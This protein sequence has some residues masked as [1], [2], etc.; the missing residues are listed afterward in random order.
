MTLKTNKKMC[1]RLVATL[2]SLAIVAMALSPLELAQ[3]QSNVNLNTHQLLVVGPDS[4]QST[5][6]KFVDFKNSQ[7]VSAHYVSTESINKTLSNGDFVL[8]LHNY[9]SQEI[10][11]SGLEYVILVGTYDQVPTKY[12]YSPSSD[13]DIADFNYKPTDWYYAV[14]NWND[15]QVGLFGGNIPQIAVGRLPV[16]DAQEL[17]QTISK[18]IFVEENLGKGSFVSLQDPNLGADSGLNVPCS[19]VPFNTN[20]TSTRLAQVLSENVSYAAT[21]THGTPDALWTQTGADK[22]APLFSSK[23]VASLKSTFGIM[24]VVA[25]FTGA[26]DLGEE[27]LARALITSPTGPALVIASSRT[28]S[29]NNYIPSAFWDKFFET[30][31]VGDSFVFSIQSY[32]SNPA[33]FSADLKAFQKYNFYLDKVIYGDVSWTINN[34]KVEVP[35]NLSVSTQPEVVLQKALETSSQNEDGTKLSGLWLTLPFGAV[36]FSSIL[37]GALWHVRRKNSEVQMGVLEKV[38]IVSSENVAECVQVE[39]LV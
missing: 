1:T 7:G 29:L 34:H 14:P 30:G 10:I 37:A 5:V 15:S 28:E 20:L 18:I 13:L 8:G 31:S 33:V 38:F 16:K 17:E 2:V 6:Q 32:L 36:S 3:A 35:V 11:Q 26:I 23:D 21:Y 9:I 19:A 27:G 12:V 39:K 25:C 4:Y 22:W 24:Y